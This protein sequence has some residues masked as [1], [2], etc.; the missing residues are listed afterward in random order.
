MCSAVLDFVILGAQK[1]GTTT[2]HEVMRGHPELHLPPGKEHPIFNRSD[3]DP[4]AAREELAQLFAGGTGLRGKASPQYLSSGVAPD[5][6]H[7]LA[8]D[9]RLIVI[10]R[11]PVERCFSHYRMVARRSGEVPD[12]EAMVSRWLDP[13]ELERARA[14][15]HALGEDELPFCVVWSE[16][17][18][19]LTRWQEVFDKEQFLLLKTEELKAR[20]EAVFR[21][22]FAFLGVDET[23][24]SPLIGQE[25]HRGGD[26]PI[27]DFRKLKAVPILGPFA[28]WVHSQ[29]SEELQ[30]KINTRNI[31]VSRKSPRAL[32]PEACARLEAHFASDWCGA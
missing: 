26:A 30:M 2:L 3:F 17:G 1:A 31:R 12:F 32:Y 24:Q 27:V 13:V 23:W 19:M 4:G 29:L 5:N 9:A 15:E 20:P 18:R 28:R 10:L 21:Q 11:D 7:Q 8:P 6:L 25:F 16:Y 14:A 22:V